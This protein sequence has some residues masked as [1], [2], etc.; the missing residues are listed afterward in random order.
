[1][2]FFPIQK[3][4]NKKYWTKFKTFSDIFRLCYVRKPFLHSVE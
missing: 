1:M 3:Y 2:A 4:A